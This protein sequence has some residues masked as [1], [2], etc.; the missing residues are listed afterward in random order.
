ME[1]QQLDEDIKTIYYKSKNRYVAPKIQNILVS[2]RTHANSKRAQ[3]HMAAMRLSSIV[4]NQDFATSTINK[5]WCTDTTY[6]Y[7]LKMA[8]HIEHL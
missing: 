2:K 3:M 6:I 1:N 5:K 7:P 4:V 8:G